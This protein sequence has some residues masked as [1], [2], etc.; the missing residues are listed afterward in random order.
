MTSASC[1]R[2]IGGDEAAQVAR[3]EDKLSLPDVDFYL[4]INELVLFWYH[5][6][7]SPDSSKRLLPQE[8]RNLQNLL[9]QAFGI[10]ASVRAIYPMSL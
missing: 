8:L 10:S 1:G 6:D 2:G 4:F 9:C 5:L 3:S 7:P